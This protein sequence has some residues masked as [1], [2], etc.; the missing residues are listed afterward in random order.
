MVSE[1]IGFRVQA[2]QNKQLTILYQKQLQVAM[3]KCIDK[4]QFDF[5]S[6]Y[7]DL[8]VG[9]LFHGQVSESKT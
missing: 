2:S 9:M 4:K 8:N 7:F 3:K 1:N 5:S 6:N